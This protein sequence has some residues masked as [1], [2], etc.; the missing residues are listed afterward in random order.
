MHTKRSRSD[1][2]TALLCAVKSHAQRSVDEPPSVVLVTVFYG[3]AF[4]FAT[5]IF[6][7]LRWWCKGLTRRLALSSGQRSEFC[8]IWCYLWIGWL[9]EVR[10]VVGLSVVEQH[11]VTVSLI[12]AI[13]W[14]KLTYGPDAALTYTCTTTRMSYLWN[15]PN[16]M[17]QW[18]GMAEDRL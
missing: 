1:T 10:F 9:V 18:S 5:T 11:Q 12:L 2:R 6:W 14:N 15:S 13:V 17:L 3:I 16:R 8:I 7:N 4:S